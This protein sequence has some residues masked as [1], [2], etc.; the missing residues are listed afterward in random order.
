MWP[1]NKRKTEIN[2]NAS[3]TIV[4]NYLYE[5]EIRLKDGTETLS[6]KDNQNLPAVVPWK[7]FLKWYH[8]REQSKSC[9]FHVKDGCIM[10]KRSQIISYRIIKTKLN[11]D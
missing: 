7:R 1:F 6:V 4:Y 10:I 11:K 5:L 2:L 9:I 8:G 3:Y